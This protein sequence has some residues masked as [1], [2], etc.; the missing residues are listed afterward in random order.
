MEGSSCLT[1]HLIRFRD[2]EWPKTHTQIVNDLD[3]E[4]D[5]PVVAEHGRPMLCNV[6]PSQFDPLQPLDASATQRQGSVPS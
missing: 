2:R 3:V 6:R 5:R 4:V 1:R